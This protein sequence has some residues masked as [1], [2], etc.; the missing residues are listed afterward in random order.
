[1]KTTL[2]VLAVIILPSLI[3]YIHNKLLKWIPY[4]WLVNSIIY[5]WHRRRLKRK[6]LISNEKEVVDMW[7]EW[8]HK[9][10]IDYW[11]GRSLMRMVEDSINNKRAYSN[12]SNKYLGKY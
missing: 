2:I 5:P 8:Q 9:W 7:F 3:V 6:L 1:M 12:V 10:F 11:F 4:R